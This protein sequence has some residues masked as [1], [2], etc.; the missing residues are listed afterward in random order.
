MDNDWT[1]A[2]GQTVV[3]RYN[4]HLHAGVEELLSEALATIAFDGQFQVFQVD[5]HRVVGVSTRV[6]TT[7]EDEIVWAIRPTNIRKA[8]RP[9]TR[10]VKN[11]APVPCESM[12][13]ILKKADDVPNTYVLVTAFIGTQAQPEPWDRNATEESLEFWSKNALVWGKEDVVLETVTDD[14]PW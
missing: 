11:R 8:A 7:D 9:Y 13:I 5:F 10:F 6:E 1:L 12:V 3:N 2:S 4:S 14:C